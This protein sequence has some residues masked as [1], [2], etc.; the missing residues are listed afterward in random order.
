MQADN[1][2]ISSWGTPQDEAGLLNHVDLVQKLDIVDLQ[3]GVEVAGEMLSDQKHAHE[4]LGSI[5]D[6]HRQ[7]HQA[8]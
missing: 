4:G 1:A 2:L 3:H 6:S 8:N 5:N 7:P